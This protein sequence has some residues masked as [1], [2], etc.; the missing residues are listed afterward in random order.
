MGKASRRKKMN[1]S[2][3]SGKMPYIQGLDWSNYDI[4]DIRGDVVMAR[5]KDT[6]CITFI[7][8]VAKWESDNLITGA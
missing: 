4:L 5:R 6:G 3:H 1:W 7:K 2:I 8:P